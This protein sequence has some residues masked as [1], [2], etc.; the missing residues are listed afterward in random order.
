MLD[1][2]G[3]MGVK[4]LK[5]GHRRHIPGVLAYCRKVFEQ[6]I[7]FD[8]S[9]HPDDSALYCVELTEKAFRSQGLALSD[10]VRIGDWEQLGRYP[11]TAFAIP[12]VTGLRPGSTDLPR[13]ARLRARQRAPW[14]LG[15]ALAGDGLR[16]GTQV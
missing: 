14:D 2:V 5:S 8:Y 12:C 15:F 4:R 13:A 11:L 16:P 3:S 6:Q 1:C 9:F 7:P 10:S